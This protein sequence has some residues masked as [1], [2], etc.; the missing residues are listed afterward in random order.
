MFCFK[1]GASPTF[2][3]TAEVSLNGISTTINVDGTLDVIADM[4]ALV[5]KGR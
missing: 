1:I 4:S 5:Y 2:N 3:G